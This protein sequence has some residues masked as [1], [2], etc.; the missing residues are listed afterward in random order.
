VEA[1]RELASDVSV[2]ALVDT[3]LDHVEA[4]AGEYDIGRA[5]LDYRDVLDAADVDAVSI[6]TP[7]ATHHPIAIDAAEAGKHVLVEKPMALNVDQATEMIDAAEANDVKLYVAASVTYSAESKFLREAVRSGDLIGDVTGASLSRGFRAP[8]F[9]YPGRRAWL[10]RPEDGGTGTWMLHGIH[11]IAQLRYIFGEVRTVYM[12]EHAT[13]SFRRP[14]IEA[15]M[16][17]LLTMRTGVNISVHQ[18][19]ETRLPRAMDGYCIYGEHGVLRASSAG[20]EFIPEDGAPQPVEYEPEPLSE[21]AQEIQAFG[22]YVAGASVGPTTGYS[23]RRTLAIV[24]AGYE[25]ARTGA[26]VE[27]DE[28]FGPI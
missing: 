3:D 8:E 10:T 11:N 26:P 21:F 12:R 17:G 19:C 9:G 23:E 14:D 1:V 25:S 2:V 22:D 20:C 4:K 15:T 24:Q 13:A 5:V 7:H 18:T 6:C 28:R 16:A 27:L